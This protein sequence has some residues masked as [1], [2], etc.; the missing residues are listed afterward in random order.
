MESLEHGLPYS[1]VSPLPAVSPARFTVTWS[2]GDVGPAGLQNFDV[3]MKDDN[4]AW[5]DIDFVSGTTLTSTDYV[6]QGG[7]TYY[8]RVRARD[9]AFNVEA[10]PATY[11]AKTTIE[12]LP[13]QTSIDPLP[14][15]GRLPLTISWRGRDP[16]GSG[17]FAYGTQYRDVTSPYWTD[18]ETRL[19][20]QATFNDGEPGHTYEFRVRG[21]D[22]AGNIESWST[23]PV[24]HTTLYAWGI[25]GAVIDHVGQ[26]VYGLST[27]LTPN[28]VGVL[29]DTTR[30]VYGAYATQADQYQLT[31]QRTGYSP[32]PTTEFPY[33]STG[34][35]LFD[36]ILPP[37]DNV[38]VNGDF[39]TGSLTG[40]SGG[41]SSVP[42]IS[43]ALRHTGQQAAR[44]GDSA[45]YGQTSEPIFTAANPAITVDNAQTV[46][47]ISTDDLG[48]GYT[49]LSYAA[50]PMT[51]TWPIAP[52][53]I[54][55]ADGVLTSLALAPD[56]SGGAGYLSRE[57][58][59]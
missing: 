46:H 39:E 11:D 30:A 58:L 20:T 21:T 18:W 31:W 56:Q 52:T 45:L 36:V 25:S 19:N 38:I 48:A 13:P 50:R 12:S 29:T 16:G 40:W 37:I 27:S 6:G 15:Y 23:V 49:S 3:Q 26:P 54:I 2:G 47:L 43:T 33:D 28:A 42:S 24:A 4:G 41:G 59:D 9:N 53:R 57:S 1:S 22:E 8:F 32:L 5:H 51:G 55:T 7:H 17:V 10:W 34:D 14:A 35:T 44:L